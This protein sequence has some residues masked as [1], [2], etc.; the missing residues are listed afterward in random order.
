[1]EVDTSTEIGKIVEVKIK[2]IKKCPFRDFS[3]YAIQDYKIKKLIE[4]MNKT[5]FWDG[6][7]IAR[8]VGEKY[9]IAFGHHRVKAA[10]R[11]FGL[12]GMIPITVKPLSDDLM[13]EMMMLENNTDWGCLPAAIDD[14]VKASRNYLRKHPEKIR[15]LLS[16]DGAE[17]KRARPGAPAIAKDTG[18]SETTVELSLQRLAWIESGEIEAKALHKM[19]S[20]A[21]ATHFAKQILAK[22]E[23]EPLAP[24]Q[25]LFLADRIVEKGKVGAGSINLVFMEYRSVGKP[26]TDPNHPN[27]H[28]LKLR[29]ATKLGFKLINTLRPFSKL[30]CYK[31]RMFEEMP[32]K[33]DISEE[34]TNEFLLML[35]HLAE[36][37]KMVC[38]KLDQEPAPFIETSFLFGEGNE[39]AIK[40]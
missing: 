4:S 8:Q 31:V 24:D 29:R 12:E 7:V 18:Y 15:E 16:S 30:N 40:E 13:R 35:P 5:G 11:V 28:E 22:R 17:V 1:M 20:Q 26:R 10:E 33:E 37:V 19:P 32:T 14:A 6:Q 25:Q 36:A 38:K 23:T 3:I 27:F 9:Q 39:S 2:D 34:A 21:A